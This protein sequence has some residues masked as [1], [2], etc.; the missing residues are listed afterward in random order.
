MLEIA[1][2]FKAKLKQKKTTDAAAVVF[3][4]EPA[5]QIGIHPADVQGALYKL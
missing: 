5:I 1:G 3:V 4:N 2:S